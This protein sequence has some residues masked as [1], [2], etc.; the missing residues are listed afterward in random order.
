MLKKSFGKTILMAVVLAGLIGISGCIPLV[1]F[2]RT[3]ELSGPIAPGALLAATTHNGAI[4]VT[5]GEVSE[6]KVIAKITT[7]ADTQENAKKL[8]DLVKVRLE[9][10]A[11]GTVV[12]IDKPEKLVNKYVGV[13]L[14]IT[15]PSDVS[16]KLKTHNGEVKVVNIKGNVEVRTHNGSVN[17]RDVGGGG[18]MTTHN[19]KVSCSNVKG[20]LKLRTHNGQIRCDGVAGDINV[21][22]HNGSAKVA[23]GE[24]AGGVINGHME[25]HNGSVEFKAP[26]GLSVKLEAR[27]HNG[28]VH[29]SLP[30]TVIGEV[31]KNRLKG[32][33]GSGEGKLF[34]KTHNG[35]INIK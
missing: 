35:S 34:L 16:L 25:T 21:R 2:E 14:T 28:S 23:Y 9:T 32:T 11:G 13:E 26:A 8:S 29:T 12:V 20:K 10:N 30:I 4:R 18:F 1:K 3:Q 19:G 7:K 22:T 6:C 33:I 24:G 31:K 5:G 27:T 15:L 17:A